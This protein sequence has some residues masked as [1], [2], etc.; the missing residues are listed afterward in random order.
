MFC[1]LFNPHFSPAL[2]DR[3]LAFRFGAK[4]KRAPRFFAKLEKALSLEKRKLAY[5]AGRRNLCRCMVII[6]PVSRGLGRRGGSDIGRHATRVDDTM[7][8]IQ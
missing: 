7:H 5:L 1:L 3:S 8:W 4:K 6:F 2:A